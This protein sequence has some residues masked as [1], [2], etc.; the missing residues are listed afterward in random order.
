VVNTSRRGSRNAVA[1]L[2]PS[3]KFVLKV[4]EGKRYATFSEIVQETG[5][6]ERT[7][8]YAL[9]RLKELG[10][11]KVMPCIADARKRIYVL[12]YTAVEEGGRGL[13]GFTAS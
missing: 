5:L 13:S 9:R 10:L 8:K 4:L 2:P 12:C 6:P 7:V 11:V 3:V 1:Q